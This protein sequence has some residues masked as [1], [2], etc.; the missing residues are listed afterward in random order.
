MQPEVIDFVGVT[1]SFM[2]LMTALLT[3]FW[4]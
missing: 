1:A 3:A 4:P 2:F